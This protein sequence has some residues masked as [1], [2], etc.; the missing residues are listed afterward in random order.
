MD[1]FAAYHALVESSYQGKKI[2][3]T[4][5]ENLIN[6]NAIDLFELEHHLNELQ[7]SLEHAEY[8][9]TLDRIG[10]GEELLSTTTDEAKKSEYRKLLNDLT[11]KLEKLR[12]K[13]ESA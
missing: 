11:V 13:E 10:K 8:Y 4:C 1:E 12:P 5:Y 7:Y 9:I 3:K 2:S 6:R